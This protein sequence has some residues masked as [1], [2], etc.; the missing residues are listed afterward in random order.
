MQ[1][2][3]CTFWTRRSC[4]LTICVDANGLYTQVCLRPALFL[5]CPVTY[6]YTCK[7]IIHWM[8]LTLCST[9]ITSEHLLS[10]NLTTREYVFGL[11]NAKILSRENNSVYSSRQT[12]LCRCHWLHV[13]TCVII[14]HCNFCSPSRCD[15]NTY[16]TVEDICDTNCKTN[17]PTT[18]ASIDST[19]VLSLVSTDG[20]GNTMTKV[21][22][23]WSLGAGGGGGGCFTLIRVRT[24]IW[25]LKKVDPNLYYNFQCMMTHLKKKY[26]YSKKVL[27]SPN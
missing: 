1:Y 14:S 25:D 27:T 6:M 17:K 9:K 20:S 10:A 8:M 26:H 19:G 15:C 3:V 21:S 23:L 7:C 22:T 4:V 2:V 13:V 5:C 24:C 18:M 11:P 16:T 12:W